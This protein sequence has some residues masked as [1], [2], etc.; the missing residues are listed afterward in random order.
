MRPENTACC[1]DLF[2]Q[3]SDF[4][5][6]ISITRNTITAERGGIQIGYFLSGFPTYPGKLAA[7]LRCSAAIRMSMQEAVCMRSGIEATQSDGPP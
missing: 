1:P 4:I 6:N 3:E 5:S 2:F 7:P